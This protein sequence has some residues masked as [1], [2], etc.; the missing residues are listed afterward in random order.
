MTQQ[1]APAPISSASAYHNISGGP[2]YILADDYR[3]TMG[4][5]GQSRQPGHIVHSAN[6][7]GIVRDNSVEKMNAVG[8]SVTDQ[9]TNKLLT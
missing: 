4:M 5:Q 3:K 9:N 2:S 6:T 8:A 7:T 1:K